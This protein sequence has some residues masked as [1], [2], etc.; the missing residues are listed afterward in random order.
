[1][2]RSSILGKRHFREPP[3]LV[4]RRYVSRGEWTCEGKLSRYC[5]RLGATEADRYSG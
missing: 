1:M 4:E 2:S 5:S 3:D